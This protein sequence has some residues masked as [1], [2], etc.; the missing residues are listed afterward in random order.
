MRLLIIEDDQGIAVSLQESLKKHYVVDVA[1]TGE[2]GLFQAEVNHPDIIILDLKLPDMDGQE[3]CGT[4]RASRISAPILI[5]TGR[6]QIEDKILMLDAGADDYL[7]KPFSLGELNAR[8]RALM[9]RN[10]EPLSVILATDDLQLD[11]ASRSAKRGATQLNLRRKEFDLL[12]YLMR[13]QGNPVSREMIL[14]HV[15]H[16]DNDIWTNAVDVHIKYLRDKVDRPFARQLI[17]TV[18]GVGYKIEDSL[19]PDEPISR[20]EVER[21]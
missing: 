5:L 6:A 1:H 3:V 17:K 9:R 20:K 18:H 19:L 2:D 10:Q 14:E 15:W 11:V 13:N 8:L 7:V 16:N 4:L 21:E 12:E